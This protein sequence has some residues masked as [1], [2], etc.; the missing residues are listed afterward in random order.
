MPHRYRPMT[1]ALREIRKYQ[2]STELLQDT[3]LAA[4]HAKRVIN[5][6]PRTFSWPDTFAATGPKSLPSTIS[7][8]YN[9]GIYEGRPVFFNTTTQRE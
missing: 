8:Q 6:E 2:N 9:T 7:K 4:I 1:A 3:N 5:Q